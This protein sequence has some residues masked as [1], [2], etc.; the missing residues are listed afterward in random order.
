MV[1]ILWEPK[2]LGYG[3]KVMCLGVKLTKGR[4]MAESRI[5]WEMVLWAHL[6]GIILIALCELGRLLI[7][8][9]SIPK[10]GDGIMEMEKGN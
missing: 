4:V 7:V 1:M 10:S 3:F 6:W 9:V 2:V 5:T 8:G